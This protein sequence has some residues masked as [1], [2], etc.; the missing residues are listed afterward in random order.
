ML[1]QSVQITRCLTLLILVLGAAGCSFQQLDPAQAARRTEVRA[2]ELELNVQQT[3]IAQQATLQGAAQP[4]TAQPSA[5]ET[6][7]SI[8]PLPGALDSPAPVAPTIIPTGVIQPI[9]TQAPPSP[10]PVETEASLTESEL[11]ERMKSAN[12]VLYEDM[13]ARNNTSRYVKDTLNRM[14]LTFKDDGNAL[15]WLIKD[16]DEGAPNGRPWDLVIL[17]LEDKSRPQGELL[18]M[19][20]KALLAGPTAVIIETWFLNDTSG[21]SAK[22]LLETCGV[23]YQSDRRGIAPAIMIMFKL[24]PDHPLL[25]QPNTDISLTDTVGYWWDPSGQQVYDTGD[26]LRLSPGSSAQLV[27]GAKGDQPTSQG[28]VAVCMDGRLI[29]QTFSSHTFTYDTGR[30]LWENFITNALRA[31]FEKDSE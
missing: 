11:A 23:E 7:D 10:A 24:V 13:V 25:N 3:I 19:A 17:A 4:Q 6:S 15:G 9:D 18:P 29:L 22:E 28:T 20:L 14:G 30:L 21:G 8:T 2:T 12:I 27:V 5:Q 16:L 1:R 26:T 31:R